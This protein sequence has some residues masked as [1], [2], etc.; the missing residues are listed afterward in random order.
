LKTKNA[1]I[2]L[3]KAIENFNGFFAFIDL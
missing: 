2:F 3:L 1:I